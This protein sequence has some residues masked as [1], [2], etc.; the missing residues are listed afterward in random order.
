LQK[1]SELSHEIAFIPS[2]TVLSADDDKLRLRSGNIKSDA[3]LARGY[4]RRGNP[5]PTMYSCVSENTGIFLG[6]RYHELHGSKL[7]SVKKSISCTL[8]FI[9]SLIL[10]TIKEIGCSGMLR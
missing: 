10:Y 1:L 7:D 9:I 2:A 4:Q 5:G 6:D 8:L 3:G